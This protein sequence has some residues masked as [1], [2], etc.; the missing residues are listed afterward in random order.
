MSLHLADSVVFFDGER[1]L[2][3]VQ[4]FG[5]ATRHLTETELGIVTRALMG[6]IYGV[7]EFDHYVSE[8][9]DA[10]SLPDAPDCTALWEAK[11]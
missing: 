9:T 5:T 2:V 6:H 4:G 7:R 8:Q 3:D 10:H 1:W 11:P